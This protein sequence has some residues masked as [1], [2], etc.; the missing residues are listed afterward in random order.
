M[1]DRFYNRRCFLQNSALFSTGLVT[2]LGY[3][4]KAIPINP[5]TPFVPEDFVGAKHCGIN[6]SVKS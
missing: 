5:F 2:S 1:P 4:R 3:Q 6:V